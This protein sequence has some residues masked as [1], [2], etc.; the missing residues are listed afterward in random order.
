MMESPNMPEDQRKF[1]CWTSMAQQRTNTT[2][3]PELKFNRVGISAKVK[4]ITEAQSTSS[5]YVLRSPT[6]RT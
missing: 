1:L 4:D 3:A 6:F 2:L 5:L